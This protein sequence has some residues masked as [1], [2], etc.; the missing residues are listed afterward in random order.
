MKPKRLA[1]AGTGLLVI[2][3][4][5][6]VFI[7]TSSKPQTAP[8]PPPTTTTTAPPPTTTAPAPTTTAPPPAPPPPK[9]AMSWEHAGAIVVH[10]H[11]VD[12]TWLGQQLRSAGFGWVAIYLGSNGNAETI[13]PEWV[14]RFVLASGLPVG[15]WT[16]LGTDPQADASFAVQL[17]KQN[18]LSFYIAD[19]EATDP[20]QPGRSQEFVAA[21]RDA[22]PTLPAALSSLCDAQGVGLQPWASAG[23][24]FLPQAYVDDFGTNV[25]PET[26]VRTAAPFAPA[27]VHPTVGSYHGQKGWVS[28]QR[29]THLLQQARTT[30]FSV[31][32]AETNMPAESWQAYGEAIRSS[33]IALRVG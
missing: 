33:H 12:P 29:Y 19:A 9:V 24:A 25:S 7:H 4:V 8:P 1:I 30:G 23:F 6:A 16:V 3:I 32:P 28:V 2:A 14:T 11:D 26:C 20:G 21:F 5:L 10:T 18:A 13:D 27:Q 22:E 15:G 31:Y 17:V